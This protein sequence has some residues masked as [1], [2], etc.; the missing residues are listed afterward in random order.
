HEKRY[1]DCKALANY[2]VALLGAAGITAYPALVHGGKSRSPVIEDFPCN[3]FNHVIVCIPRAKDSLWLDCTNDL[4]PS[5]FLG[6]FAENR[7]ALLLTPHGG[8][9]VH[10]PSTDAG[11][12][13]FA[14]TGRVVLT[15]A[16]NA[17][18]IFITKRTGNQAIDVREELA[19]AS[20]R[21][22][23][24][25]IQGD[26]KVVGTTVTAQS[27]TGLEPTGR[28]LSIAAQVNLPNLVNLTG[29]RIFFQPEVSN[30]NVT[31]PRDYA[32]R[33]SPVRC[34]YPYIDV[35][36]I[37]YVIPAGYASEA[38]PGA[39]VLT[40]PFGSFRSSAL[41]LSDTAILFTRRIEIR[42]TLIPATDYHEYVK[43]RQAVAR[44]DKAQVVLTRKK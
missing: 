28:T 23:L 36:S 19:S 41:A 31:P 34:L 6:D 15:P 17:S 16:G 3:K 7:P 29:G 18:G 24:E 1:G 5:G 2:M 10:T 42:S 20:P 13:M 33:K 11:D 35:D 38:L 4:L 37:E 26:I 40:A 8:V 9:L 44:S 14:R 27:I 25:W 32:N 21:E 30:R 22:R 39:A 43:F 12:N